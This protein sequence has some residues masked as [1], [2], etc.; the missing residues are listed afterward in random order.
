MAKSPSFIIICSFFYRL[1]TLSS[2]SCCS[3]KASWEY[4]KMSTL[5]S[6]GLEMSI[7]DYHSWGELIYHLFLTYVL[8]SIFNLFL[9]VSFEK[10]SSS[11]YNNCVVFSGRSSPFKISGFAIDLVDSAQYKCK[12]KRKPWFVFY[13]FMWTC[14]ETEYFRLSY[15]CFGY[16]CQI[17]SVGNFLPRTCPSRWRGRW[18]M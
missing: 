1:C 7:A 11:C 12:R 17:S 2:S 6:G 13:S 18:W 4:L 15:E 16:Y 14:W 9:T 5:S 8:R 3:A 10:L